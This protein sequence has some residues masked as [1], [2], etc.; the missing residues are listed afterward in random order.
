MRFYSTE[1]RKSMA[2]RLEE[3]EQ[4]EKTKYAEIPERKIL[5][6]KIE[7]SFLR[8]LKLNQIYN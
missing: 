5:P 7:L 4:M 3:L 2:E 1:E 8:E 6:R